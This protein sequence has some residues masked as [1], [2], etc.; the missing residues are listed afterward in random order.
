MKT[1]LIDFDST[2]VT[3]ESLDELANIA[4]KGRPDREAI[5]N[6]LRAITDKG[7][8]GEI[9]FDES[10]DLRLKLFGANRGHVDAVVALLKNRISPS[11]LEARGWFDRH[12]GRIYVISGGF[13]DYIVPVVAEL[14]IPASQVFA[15]RFQY[16][17]NGNITGYDS[18][19]LPSQAGGKAK[20]AAALDLKGPVVAI[21]DGFTDY[22]IKAG[23]TAHEFWVFTETNHRAN[24]VKKADKVLSGFDGRCDCH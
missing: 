13:E 20:Q 2:L 11:A 21:G 7:M 1:H 23:G 24:V 18:S 6:E 19:R 5:M 4:L 8:T 10:L 3:A 14:G 16:D 17:K 9:G 12:A 15:N 22:E